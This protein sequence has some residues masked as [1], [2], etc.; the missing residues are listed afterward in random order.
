MIYDNPFYLQCVKICLE[1]VTVSSEIPQ[2]VGP[3]SCIYIPLEQGG[4]VI[5]PGAH[6]EYR[7]I[8]ETYV[9]W[10]LTYVDV[11]HPNSSAFCFCK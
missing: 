3:G 11:G 2:P 8:Y 7:F 6:F 5:P 10:Q 4:P 1:P 9:M